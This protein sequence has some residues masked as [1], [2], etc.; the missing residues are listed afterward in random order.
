MNI[1]AS[2]E[3][4]EDAVIS[5]QYYEEYK[6]S[7]KDLFKRRQYENSKRTIESQ[8]SYLNENIWALAKLGEDAS[9]RENVTS[10]IEG[11]GSLK[12]LKQKS[13]WNKMLV[14]IS[15]LKKAVPKPRKENDFTKP[16]ILPLE[17]RD[18][19]LADI[20][21]LTK[22]YG[23]GCYR[24]AVILCGRILETCLQRKY[25]EATGNDI[26]EKNPGIGLGKLIAKMLENKIHLDP[27][28]TQQIHLVNQVRI[29]SVHK[30]QSVFYPTKDQTQAMILY[31]L[32]TV[33]KLFA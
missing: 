20:D 16:K 4:L 29:F 9:E 14:L 1:K 5:F 17:A 19:I 21:E 26:L 11:I 12:N 10:M 31:T 15:G 13:E 2:L 18:D 3:R 25:F 23:S 33:S 6:D 22:C 27:G 8:L 30:K 7:E 28:L 32:D 24:S